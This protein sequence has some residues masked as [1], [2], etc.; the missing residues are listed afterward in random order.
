MAKMY[1]NPARLKSGPKPFGGHLLDL[2]LPDRT[3]LRAKTEKFRRYGSVCTHA[4]LLIKLCPLPPVGG[5][6]PGQGP[7]TSHRPGAGRG[8]R[9]YPRHRCTDAGV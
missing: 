1:R 8:C 7:D 9:R 4:L 2:S 6:V 5:E 3:K